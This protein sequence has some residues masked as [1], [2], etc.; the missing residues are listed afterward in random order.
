MVSQDPRINPSERRIKEILEGAKTIAVVGVS[1]KPERDSYQVASYLVSHGYRIIP[2]NPALDSLFG[3]KAYPD[4]KS[5]PDP[6]DIV[7]IFRRP[8]AVPAIVEEA[9]QAGAKVV[10]MQLGIVHREAAERA[11]SEGLEVVMDRCIKIEH[12]RGLF[13]PLF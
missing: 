13:P 11:A 4:L 1:K 7:D 9:I 3:E 12:K 5:I 10:W 8:D 6:V 2:V